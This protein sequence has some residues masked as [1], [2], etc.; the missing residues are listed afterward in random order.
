MIN[1]LLGLQTEDAYLRA[2]NILKDRFGDPFKVYESYRQKLWA[3]PVCSTATE[4]QEFSDFLV[5]TEET[6]KTV[7]YLKEFDNFSAIRQLAARLPT[8]YTNGETLLRR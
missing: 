1:G 6:M 5:M 3:W 8:Y 4:L 2:R 7:K